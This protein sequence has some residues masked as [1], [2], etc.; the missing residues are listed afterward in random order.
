MVYHY[1]IYIT[2]DDKLP[3]TYAKFMTIFTDN[4]I[5]SF[6]TLGLTDSSACITYLMDMLSPYHTTTTNG[7]HWTFDKFAFYNLQK[8]CTLKIG[9]KT[10]S[11]SF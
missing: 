10:R 2:N 5:N 6:V 7:S 1:I 9:P 11:K 4:F 8:N 3:T